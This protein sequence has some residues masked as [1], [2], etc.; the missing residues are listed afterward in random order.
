MSEI[1]AIQQKAAQAAA[2]AGD[3]ISLADFL[4]TYRQHPQLMQ[5]YANAGY[6][7]ANTDEQN[8]R[9]IIANTNYFDNWDD[10]TK[11]RE[12]LVHDKDLQQFEQ[13]ADLLVAGEHSKLKALLVQNPGLIGMRSVGTITVRCRCG[14]QR[15]LAYLH[16]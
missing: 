14:D 8:A 12:R 2:Q 16:R 4:C 9:C 3:I 13:A 11:F 5:L 1:P 7:T 6:N 15:R 10:Y